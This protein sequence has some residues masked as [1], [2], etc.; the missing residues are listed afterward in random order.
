M[1]IVTVALAPIMV[2]SVIQGMERAHTD[3][4]Q[5]DERL[6]ETAQTAGSSE[7][8]MLAAAEQIAR[9]LANMPAVR[10]A[11]PDCSRALSDALKG[12]S[13][14]TNIARIDD[15]GHVVCAANPLA[16]GRDVSFRPV[17]HLAMK[18]RDFVL[19]E[20]I[21]SPLT[22]QP[23]I[24]GMLPLLKDGK[25]FG[26]IAI[27]ID[28]RWL[29]YMVHTSKLPEGSVVAV[30][31]HSGA[32]I[33]S[34]NPDIAAHVFAHPNIAANDVRSA[35]DA[36]GH[37]WRYAVAPLL[38]RNV[39]VG[40]AMRQAT[41][42]GATYLHVGTDFVLPVFMIALTWLAIWFGAER[43]VTRWITQLRRISMAYRS[44]HYAIRPS[45]AG[46]P[47]EFQQ[48][49][50]ALS[51]MAD[52]IQ[53]RD[54]N[55]REAVAQ[56]TMM[57][58]EVHHRVKN[59]LQIVMSLLNLQ[60]GRVRDPSARD[61]LKQA[62]MRIN[63]LALVHRTLHEIEDQSF[64]QLDRLLSDLTQQTCDGFGAQREGLRVETVM[65]PRLVGSHIAVPLALFTAEA[66]TNI[67]KHAYP[68]ARA[69]R[70]RVTLKQAGENELV[71]AIEDDGVGF[72]G[73]DLPREDLSVGSQLI[74]TFAQQVGG[75][76]T[77]SS[78]PGRGTLVELR[79]P[80]PGTHEPP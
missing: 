71:L 49:G 38:G 41:L 73:A 24:S 48:L 51:A 59:N 76:V 39:Y 74:N 5:V 11:T 53:E 13:F 7:E 18:S 6:I 62:Q 35:P 67:F 44:G 28:V 60:A 78:V 79:F 77:T 50:E 22:D 8:N 70:I 80:E 16:L 36:E 21:V 75:T 33:A 64:I 25:A 69:G 9:A 23:V 34:D 46:A 72:A 57:V 12:L 56:K 45:L 10:D 26:V 1:L 52:S 20:R 15:K 61:A 54:R 43:L 27:G 2:A 47:Q 17:W 55:L 66:L 4:I 19:S 42:F 29:D 30:F 40:F 3:T 58:R 68:G 32:I 31:D 37:I 65:V 63:A 14:F